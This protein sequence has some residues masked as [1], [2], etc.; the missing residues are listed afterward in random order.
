MH[1][2]ENI[3]T[4]AAKF[5]IHCYMLT[6]DNIVGLSNAEI[7]QALGS[8]FKTYRLQARLTQKEAA[9]HA[10]VSLITLRNFETGKATNITMSN[11]LSLLR[12]IDNLAP[13]SELL[14][15]LPISPYVL[16]QLTSNQPKRVRHEK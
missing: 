9:D 16:E 12:V 1:I 8:M 15:V 3:F 4:F 5:E 14:P 13:I 2:R 10:G 6:K 11:F 7:I